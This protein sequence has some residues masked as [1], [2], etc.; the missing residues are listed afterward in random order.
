MSVPR[1]VTQR[2]SG[3][4][5]KANAT[6]L[7]STIA[8]SIIA[9]KG[10][11]RIGFPY[12]R[13]PKTLR[14]KGPIDELH[15]LLNFNVILVDQLK[16]WQQPLLKH[17]EIQI[18]APPTSLEAFQEIF[19]PLESPIGTSF[20]PSTPKS[21]PNLLTLSLG[22]GS[23]GYKQVCFSLK[24]F[25]LKL[26]QIIEAAFTQHSQKGHSLQD[27]SFDRVAECSVCG[28]LIWGLAP[29]G[30]TCQ[31]CD[32]SIHHRCKS[33]LKEACTKDSKS[34]NLSRSSVSNVSMSA[35]SGTPPN[36]TSFSVPRSSSTM[37]SPA[38]SSQYPTLPEQTNSSGL[39]SQMNRI[40]RRFSLKNV[41]QR[42]TSLQRPNLRLNATP[43]IPIP[44]WSGHN[45][46]GSRIYS[47]WTVRKRRS[48]HRPSLSAMLTA[49]ASVANSHNNAKRNSVGNFTSPLE[50]TASS[51]D[52]GDS[53]SLGLTASTE[54]IFHCR[55][56]SFNELMSESASGS[57]LQ[58]PSFSPSEAP[59]SPIINE[60]AKV[61]RSNS[62]FSQTHHRGG[63]QVGLTS[64][65][66][67]SQ[68]A[69]ELIN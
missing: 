47:S 19:Q 56:S 60:E 15:M 64:P 13:D 45:Y 57:P 65:E 28:G 17:R 14:F 55:N 39:L 2:V 9:N 25:N 27:R 61:K 42:R 4:T 5:S 11:T 44:I 49:E 3:S 24:L 53:R 23:Q 29:Q 37:N 18:L 38:S 46:R 58:N 21:S 22:A 66:P 50:D 7:L 51:G 69:R 52:R 26:F 48:H 43:A 16:I 62:G 34:S 20:H 35:S 63:S 10:Y 68:V 40:S 67:I 6:G 8:H 12:Q 36:I 1:L 32:I 59:I 41:I 33:G 31:A 30:L 54:D